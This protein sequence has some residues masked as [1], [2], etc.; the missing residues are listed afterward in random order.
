MAL[1]GTHRAV[2]RCLAAAVGALV[3]AACGGEDARTREEARTREN[4]RTRSAPAGPSGSTASGPADLPN[5]GPC[6]LT[7]LGSVPLLLGGGR[8]AYVEPQNVIATDSG[9]LL[10]G[11]PS[12]LWRR[13]TAPR[14]TVQEAENAFMAALVDDSGVRTIEPPPGVEHI[15]HVRAAALTDGRWG[16]IMSVVPADSAPFS[17]EVERVWYGEH[18]GRSWAPVEELP[19]PPGGSVQS[20]GSTELVAA[21]DRLVWTVP[22]SRAD[23]QWMLVQ[24]ERDQSG[25]SRTVVTEDPV[26]AAALAYVPASGLWLA[27]AG[28]DAESPDGHHSLRLY[29]RDEEWRLVRRVIELG[30]GEH[31]RT[32]QLSVDSTGLTMTWLLQGAAG[33]AAMAALGVDGASAPE[34]VLLDPDAMQV[35]PL[36]LDERTPAWLVARELPSVLSSELLVVVSTRDGPVTG[37]ALPNPYTGYFSATALGSRITIVGPEFNPHPAHPTVRS[38]FTH[39]GASCL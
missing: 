14:G 27:V 30:P 2:P 31:A 10:V 6:A 11:S 35:I 24:L 1:G 17:Q 36:T 8:E 38:L 20:F 33:S 21:G 25:W 19:L 23:G 18:D 16:A 13:V 39:L 37:R 15:E 32:P 12:Y 22:V 29:R 9:T 28:P 34:P 7:P 4:A 3:L 26:E 5:G